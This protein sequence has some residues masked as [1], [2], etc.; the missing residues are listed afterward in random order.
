MNRDTSGLVDQM[1][2]AI[3]ADYLPARLRADRAYQYAKVI[4]CV[5][6]LSRHTDDAVHEIVCRRVGFVRRG[7]VEKALQVWRDEA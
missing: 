6:D 2:R 7:A 3:A 4:L 5:P 1:A